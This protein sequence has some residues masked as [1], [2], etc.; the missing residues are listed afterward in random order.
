MR[1]VRAD[2]EIVAP[3][4]DGWLRDA[5]CDLR[6][7]GEDLSQEAFEGASADADLILTCYRPI[8][9]KLLAGAPGLKGIIKYGVGVD[10]IDI[11]AAI[12]QGVPVTNVPLYAEETVAEAAFMLMIALAK[13]LVPLD[14]QMQAAGWAWP[15]PGWLGRDIAGRTVGLVGF[16]RIGRSMA[17]ICA[18]GFRARVLAYDPYVSAEEITAAGVEHCAS[19]EALLPQCDVVSLHCVLTE[20]TRQMIGAEQLALMKPDALLINVSRG[21]L[22]DEAALIAALDAKALGGAGLD[23]FSREPLAL[24]DH[25]LA[26]L[27]GRENV[28]LMPHLAF[29]TA[30]AMERLEREVIARC[31]EVLAGEPLLVTSKDPRLRAQSW[32]VRFGP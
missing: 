26:P 9:A 29:Y 24:M 1:V 2:A 15:E 16:G 4:I 8:T 22:V 27:F 25:P 32:G 21:A 5:G 23:T 3:L 11:P 30:D 17:R 6:L 14:R 12:Q 7:L 28:I 18:A 19:L 10:A 20:E 13:R 31:Q